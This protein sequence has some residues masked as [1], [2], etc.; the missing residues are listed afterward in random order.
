MFWTSRWQV[1]D[2]SPAFRMICC[3]VGSGSSTEKQSR[4]SVT[5][6]TDQ[7]GRSPEAH[8]GSEKVIADAA[9]GN[10]Q[11]APGTSSAGALVRT[12]PS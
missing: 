3:S 6:C 7:Q 10:G 9:D 8:E 12:P 11:P 2:G 4:V 5:L 1:L